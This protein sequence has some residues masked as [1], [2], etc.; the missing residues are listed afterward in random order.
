MDVDWLLRLLNIVDCWI[1]LNI[2]DCWSLIVGYCWLLIVDRLLIDLLNIVYLCIVWFV[3]CFI[4]IVIVIVLCCIVFVVVYRVLCL[5]CIVCCYVFCNTH[6]AND[7]TILR[8]CLSSCTVQAAP[9]FEKS[10]PTA[11]SSCVRIA[12]LPKRFGHKFLCCSYWAVI[13]HNTPRW[14]S[15]Y[16]FK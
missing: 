5:M 7:K 14:L 16:F 11:C 1:L 10:S 3:C 8:P 2:I 12:N 4:V 15:C 13:S 6:I 9:T